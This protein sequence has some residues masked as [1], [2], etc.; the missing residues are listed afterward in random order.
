MLL[1]SSLLDTD[2]EQIVG[3][4]EPKVSYRYEVWISNP[5]MDHRVTLLKNIEWVRDYN[6]AVADDIRVIFT[7]PGDVY[8]ELIMNYKDHLEITIHKKS[9]SETLVGS[10]RYKLIILTNSADVQ[11]EMIAR[12]NPQQLQQTVLVDLEVQA[13]DLDVY[14][15]ND[16]T[17]EGI[18]KDTN[19][20][21]VMRAELSDG[22]SKIDYGQGP[23][24][25]S[26]DIIEPHNENDYGHITIPT[27]T[28]L[29]DLPIWLQNGDNYGVYNGSIGVYSQVYNDK[30]YLFIFPPYDFKRYE[31]TLKRLVLF[32]TTSRKYGTSGR[33]W[34]V[35][36]DILKIIPTEMTTLDDKRD[37][38]TNLGTSISYT[39]ADNIFKSYRDIKNGETLI[40]TKKS[41]VTTQVSRESP[42]GTNKTTYLGAINNAYKYRSNIVRNEMKVYQFQWKF[43]DI[44]LIY[45]GMPCELVMEDNV[46]GIIHLRGCVQSTMQ[47]YAN[48]SKETM[49]LLNVLVNN[50]MFIVD[51]EGYEWSNL[52][53]GNADNKYK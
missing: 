52:I 19:V 28:R 18:H 27:G 24:E 1:N 20:L 4:D 48:D 8:K 53:S 47:M 44:D 3:S 14:S 12:M 10:T 7:L 11:E 38:Y 17:I 5:V 35:D 40:G 43:C 22:I 30:K 2:I 21:D 29:L 25:M 41:N 33:T 15:L 46:Y 34:K 32:K 45:P 51:R 39:D 9:G 37:E 16:I 23:G 26:L 13:V 49:G 36:G 31:D 50:P 6:S 42:D